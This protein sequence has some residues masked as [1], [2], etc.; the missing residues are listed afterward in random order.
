M[1]SSFCNAHAVAQALAHVA[2]VMLDSTFRSLTTYLLIDAELS[3]ILDLISS[4]FPS[5]IYPHV[6]VLLRGL[7]SL[8][9]LGRFYHLPP[10]H[11]PSSRCSSPGALGGQ[12]PSCRPPL[13]TQTNPPA[14]TITPTNLNNKV[15]SPQRSQ[16]RTQ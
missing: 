8:A 2:H 6:V 13:P 5:S 16:Y 3:S 1:L 9:F 14:I 10:P 7:Y 4:I 15:R 12:D 11:P